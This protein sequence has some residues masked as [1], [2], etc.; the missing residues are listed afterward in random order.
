MTILDQLA[1]HARER[2]A[3]DMET[4]SPDVMRELALHGGAGN[5]ADE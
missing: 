1:T 5:G 3:A 4:T 2:V